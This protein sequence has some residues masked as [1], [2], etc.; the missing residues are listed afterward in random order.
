MPWSAL[1]GLSILK[2]WRGITPGCVRTPT[3]FFFPRSLCF[4]KVSRKQQWRLSAIL[5]DGGGL[6]DAVE[7]HAVPHGSG[8]EAEAYTNGPRH[9]VLDLEGPGLAAIQ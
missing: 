5:G 3:I 2:R 8:R 4:V 9:G 7:D 1:S 6:S